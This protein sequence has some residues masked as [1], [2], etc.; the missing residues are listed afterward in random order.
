MSKNYY[1]IYFEPEDWVVFR[2]VK[3][4]EAG[5]FAQATYPSPLPFYGAIRSAL[6][7]LHGVEL[8]YHK[9]PEIPEK[10]R[11]LVGDE[12][13]PG[14]ITMFGPFI[15]SEE[16]GKKRHFF[17][18]PKNVYKKNG[19]LKKM[20]YFE[21]ETK[22]SEITLPGVTWIKEITN[23]EQPEDPFI[24]LEQLERFQIGEDFIL[25][26]PRNYVVEPKVGVALES[27]KKQVKESMLY[28]INTYRFKNGGFF[29]ITD[30]E[31]TKNAVEQLEGVFLGGKQR[32]ARIHIETVKTKIFELG[33]EH[34]NDV[35]VGV[36]LLTP[37]IYDGGIVPKELSFGS[38]KILAV[39]C[40]RK[41]IISGWDYM[42]GKPKPIYHAVSPGT[43]YYL[44]KFVSESEILH[45][46]KLNLFG[47]GRFIYFK[48]EKFDKNS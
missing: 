2:E 47:F 44:D 46:S 34:F 28:T 39:A 35:N 20:E 3:R 22:I 42:Y 5:G 4:F 7:K 40:G 41:M 23:V 14:K 17:P 9:R 33:K 37:A 11:E 8:R 29:M 26:N 21:Y 30:S 25:E 43:V 1:F 27:G 10:L 38:A 19:K 16:N 45:K 15:Y 6:L 12:N 36:M 24:E 18:A 48:Y 32:W 31:E 13:H